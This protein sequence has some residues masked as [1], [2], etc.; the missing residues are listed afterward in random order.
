MDTYVRYDSGSNRYR[1]VTTKKANRMIPD[2]GNITTY[3]FEYKNSSRLNR[4]ASPLVEL[5][6]M[7]YDYGNGDIGLYYAFDNEF[8]TFEVLGFDAATYASQ[9]PSYKY[10]VAY[11]VGVSCPIYGKNVWQG[12]VYYN[13]YGSID[14]Y[15]VDAD[16]DAY[17]A[18]KDG[19]RSNP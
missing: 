7:T 14:S 2:L 4:R 18:C 8:D 15:C 6:W 19:Y 17:N 10:C 9:Y 13:Q 16:D 12:E 1:A 11:T 5:T 3:D